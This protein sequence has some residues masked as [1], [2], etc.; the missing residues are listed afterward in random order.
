MHYLY[1]TMKSNKLMSEC[2]FRDIAN[3]GQIILHSAVLSLSCWIQ[4][5]KSQTKASVQGP[6]CGPIVCWRTQRAHVQRRPD[7]APICDAAR[8]KRPAALT[9]QLG[10]GF[11]E[12]TVCPVDRKEKTFTC[13]H[14]HKTARISTCPQTMH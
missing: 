6:T 5:R 4:M 11:C 13:F 8:D 9:E 12:T 10:I 3:L 14:F 1:E 2:L 7:K